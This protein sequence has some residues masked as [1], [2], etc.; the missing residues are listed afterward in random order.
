M[1]G[2]LAWRGVAEQAQL[3]DGTAF[4]GEACSGQGQVCDAAVASGRHFEKP[5]SCAVQDLERRRRLGKERVLLIGDT[6]VIAN[7]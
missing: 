5:E 3:I 2:Y 6:I 7:S 1:H 4:C